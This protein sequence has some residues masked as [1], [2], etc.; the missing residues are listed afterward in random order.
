MEKAE[1][2]CIESH[3]VTNRTP[4]SPA[5]CPECLLTAVRN[6]NLVLDAQISTAFLKPAILPFPELQPLGSWA[7]RG[8][9]RS[10]FL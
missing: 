10:E 3:N 9:F 5:C 8:S 6:R 1:G 2:P 4:Q 7:I